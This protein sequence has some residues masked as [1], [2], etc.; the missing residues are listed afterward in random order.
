MMMRLYRKEDHQQRAREY[1]SQGDLS[2]ALHGVNYAEGCIIVA[3][4]KSIPALR[5][6]IN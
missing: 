5:S 2:N 4:E 3:E 6:P 1:F